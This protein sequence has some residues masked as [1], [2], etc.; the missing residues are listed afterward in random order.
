MNEPPATQAN[1]SNLI[2]RLAA[3]EKTLRAALQ[4]L[5]TLYDSLRRGKPTELEALRANQEILAGQL[6]DLSKARD[7]AARSLALAL[8]LGDQDI[9][10]ASLIQHISDPDATLLKEARERLTALTAEMTLYRERNANL[11]SHLRSY[12]RNVLSAITAVDA[13]VRYGRSG[14]FVSQPTGSRFLAKG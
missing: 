2:D 12:F 5:I 4:S 1:C 10:L 9:I 13:P 11:L 7:E 14:G 3:E 8:G 6:T